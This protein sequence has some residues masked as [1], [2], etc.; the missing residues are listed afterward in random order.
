[1]SDET[2]VSSTDREAAALNAAIEWRA[3]RRRCPSCSE[4]AQLCPWGAKLFAAFDRS[5]RAL[6]DNMAARGRIA[7]RV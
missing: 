7:G 5:L 2:F 4:S 6:A 1:M 3:H